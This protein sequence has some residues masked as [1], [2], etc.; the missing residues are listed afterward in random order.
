MATGTLVKIIIYI[1][2][3]ATIAAAIGFALKRMGIL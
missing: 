3:F 2:L 1:V